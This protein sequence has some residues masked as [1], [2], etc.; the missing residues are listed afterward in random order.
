MPLRLFDTQLGVQGMESICELRHCLALPLPQCG[1]SH[2][3][4]FIV[5]NKIVLF[6]DCIHKKI[7]SGLGPI[8]SI[9][10]CRNFLLV[11]FPPMFDMGESLEKCGGDIFPV[12]KIVN[13]EI[14]F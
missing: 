12:K 5:I 14:T 13:N 7:P 1:P 10:L 9:F 3:L 8:Y 4:V 11:S 6:L 2:V